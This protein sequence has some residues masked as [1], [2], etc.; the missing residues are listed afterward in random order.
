MAVLANMS[1]ALRTP[2]NAIVGYSE[3]LA[4]G[5]SK[6]PFLRYFLT[7]SPSGAS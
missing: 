3:L 6:S 4:D 1:H 7:S 5:N 2:L